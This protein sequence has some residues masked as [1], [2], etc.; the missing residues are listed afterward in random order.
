MPRHRTPPIRTVSTRRRAAD[1]LEEPPSL[2]LETGMANDQLVGDT[3]SELVLEA[4][5]SSRH[6]QQEDAVDF[7]EELRRLQAEN[8]RLRAERSF[9]STMLVH[10][11][12]LLPYDG[13]SEWEEYLTHVEVV[14]T[15]NQ[16]DED[17]RAQSVASSLRGTALSV[18]NSLPIRDRTQ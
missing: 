13:K 18:L 7:G 1:P 14:S 3:T 5:A 17:R 15:L 10:E 8:S 11:A 6:R 16:W 2:N 9:S 4:S 12:P